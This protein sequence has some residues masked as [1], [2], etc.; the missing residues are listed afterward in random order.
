MAVGLSTAIFGHFGFFG[1]Y[2]SSGFS[3][4]R[5]AIYGDMQSLVGW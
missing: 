3:E 2:T 5:P 4:I 1:G